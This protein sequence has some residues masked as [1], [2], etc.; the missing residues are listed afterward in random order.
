ME[1]EVPV[2]RRHCL[3]PRLAHMETFERLRQQCNNFALLLNVDQEAR[4]AVREGGDFQFAACQCLKV[5]VVGAAFV[6]QPPIRWGRRTDA[7]EYLQMLE[8]ELV[9]TQGEQ[10]K[11]I[12]FTPH[13]HVH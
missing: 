7:Q 3:A 11:P 8:A 12:G 13:D 5:S 9:A 6:S 2:F 10:R 4:D 1:Q